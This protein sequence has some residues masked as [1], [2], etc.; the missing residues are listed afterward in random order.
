M[1]TESG[2]VP[3][4][5]KLLIRLLS[6]ATAVMLAGTALLGGWLATPVSA[7]GWKAGGHWATAQAIKNQLPVD[8]RI[9]KAMEAQPQCLAWG[10]N[11]PD[12]SGCLPSMVQE[13][14]PWFDVYH[15]MQNGSYA[16]RML[17]IALSSNDDRQIAFAAGWL[18]HIQ[19]DMAVHGLLVNPESGVY[20]DPSS[21]RDLHGVLEGYADPVVWSAADMGNLPISKY[22]PASTGDDTGKL[23]RLFVTSDDLTARLTVPTDGVLERLVDRTNR[24]VI[25][26]PASTSGGYSYLTGS[27]SLIYN[28][29]AQ[30]GDYFGPTNMRYGE[31]VFAKVLSAAH[32]GTDSFSNLV[33]SL[34]HRKLHIYNSLSDSE[35]K[36]AE[37]GVYLRT[38]SVITQTRRQR[39]KAAFDQ[40]VQDSVLLLEEATLGDYSQFSDA[41]VAD[42]GLDGRPVG[43][44]Q[45]IVKTGTSWR[46]NGLGIPWDGPGTNHYP[47]FK[48]QYDDGSTREWKLENSGY[49]DFESGDRDI[50][51]LNYDTNKPLHRITR[52]VLRL[53][54]DQ[55][56]LDLPWWN[57]YDFVVQANGRT[58]YQPA[59]WDHWTEA[60]SYRDATWYGSNT[61]MT[62]MVQ[63]GWP[64]SQPAWLKP[65][66]R[67][68]LGVTTILRNNN[69]N[70]WSAGLPD[71]WAVNQGIVAPA[72]PGDV[73][74]GGGNLLQLKIYGRAFDMTSG[75]V[76]QRVLV[77]PGHRY[78][79][80]S[81]A[82]RA[83]G[84]G[85]RLSL[86]FTDA[87][88]AQLAN[89]IA[90]GADFP[91]AASGTWYTI[92]NT[93]NAAAAT[94]FATVHLGVNSPSYA[95]AHFDA[96]QLSSD[97][98][99]DGSLEH[100]SDIGADTKLAPDGWR[101]NFWYPGDLSLYYGPSSARS[102]GLWGWRLKGQGPS[103]DA[104][105]Q[106]VLATPGK[107]YRMT[108]DVR[109]ENCSAG[110]VRLRLEF[111]NASEQLISQVSGTAS[112]VV[113]STSQFRPVSLT[114]T[115]PSGTEI[116][117][118][119]IGMDN[120]A[121]AVFDNVRLTAP[122]P[123]ATTARPVA[124][125]V[126]AGTSAG[127][128]VRVTAKSAL[129]ARSNVVVQR[130][131]GSYWSQVA[132]AVV[133]TG[134]GRVYF[135]P[136]RT[137]TYRVVFPARGDY[138]ASAS[139][140]F[141]LSVRAA[142]VGLKSGSTLR[143]GRAYTV[144]AVLFPQHPTGSYAA[145][146]QC[147]HYEGGRW[148]TRQTYRMK[149]SGSGGYSALRCT[150]RLKYRG[151]WK[152]RVY[153]KADSY[154]MRAYSAS[155]LLRV[156]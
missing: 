92:H 106:D 137:G 141:R 111:L 22:A 85:E 107:T 47:Y 96:V 98:L 83:V 58:I 124:T 144:K 122:V 64:T 18:T 93:A 31:R 29:L 33:A 42:K 36:L 97:Y 82:K 71:Y 153:H 148:V 155:R 99:R 91:Q 8:N 15:Y 55:Y 104:L 10:T 41:W 62:T 40:C 135:A 3:P 27:G 63:G 152:I 123:S 105:V 13:R 81:F 45:I 59:G 7:F 50:Y 66:T 78:R 16:A 156:R 17:R 44:F 139:A 39:V 69:F 131:T 49:D 52:I 37:H 116:V 75:D 109:A 56:G 86:E 19:G 5:D 77:E 28:A 136:V 149:A 79:L 138:L 61:H 67:P 53:G 146:L 38:S 60:G 6:C 120:G 23:Y 76:S 118:V 30:S 121:S 57:M 70:T 54:T 145:Y 95:V 74:A 114:G 2:L 115:A 147:K 80:S 112:G 129:V 20:V 12:L 133:P 127:I 101:T 126:V 134:A 4:T 100:Y 14:V 117:R 94:R 25:L 73:G 143:R 84:L 46:K 125:T 51:F 102:D 48:V 1:H 119:C 24:E 35:A 150:V 32:F 72:D 87:N 9:R 11:G 21:D 89:N 43:S 90:N 142:A 103:T 34:R 65:A 110:Q 108:T 26:N 130:W 88:G 151:R 113:L 154:A 132:G 68:V 128:D 140:S